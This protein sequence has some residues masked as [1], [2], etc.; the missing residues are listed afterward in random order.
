MLFS[1]KRIIIIANER[2]NHRKTIT[3]K[4]CP[5]CNKV[6]EDSLVYCTDDGTALIA[7][8][9]VL[10]SESGEF[11]TEEETLIHHEPIKIEIPH[12]L[13][14][15]PQI[16]FQIPASGNVIPIVVEKQ[17]NTGKYLL[18][19]IIGL[20]LGSVLVAGIFV[21]ILSQIRSSGNENI[22]I[23]KVQTSTGKHNERN[24]TRKDSEFNGFVLNENVN[25]RNAPNSSVL[26][27]LP[28]N[29][30]LE[31]VERENLWYRVICE[32]GTGGWMHGNTIRFNEN[33][34]S[35]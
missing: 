6:F 7:D 10:P 16:N 4:K 11:E 9:F 3:M 30:R 5:Q 21:L 26:D 22:P 13:P 35:F 25:L 29:D 24:K 23:E 15:T 8:N 14:P 31:I 17:R 34:T 2:E 33:A 32:H 27:T 1:L 28:K 18:T 20:V 12:P 19:L